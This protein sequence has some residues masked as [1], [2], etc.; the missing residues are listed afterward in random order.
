MFFLNR[1]FITAAVIAFFIE[2]AAIFVVKLAYTGVDCGLLEQ[3]ICSLPVFF[4]GVAYLVASINIYTLGI[5]TIL[6]ALVIGAVWRIYRE[7][8][9]SGMRRRDIIGSL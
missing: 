3:R 8:R 5:P 2:V 1:S 9:D 6:L 7:L 4:E